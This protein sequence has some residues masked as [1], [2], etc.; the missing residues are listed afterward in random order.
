MKLCFV[1]G[2]IFAWGKYGGFGRATRWIARDLAA[3]GHEVTAVVACGPGQRPVETL[4]GI[5][6]LGYQPRRFWDALGL[7]RECDADVYHSQE[8]SLATVLAQRARP[9]RAHVVTSRDPRLAYDWCLEFARPTISRARVVANLLYEDSPLVHRAVRRADQVACTARFLEPRVRR[10]YRL[11]AAPI[12]LPSPVEL[13]DRVAKAGRPTVCFLSRWDR[14]KRPERFLELADRF[15]EVRFIA[16]GRSRDARFDRALR[17]QYGGRPN[18][19]M[20]GFVDQFAGPRLSEILSES[21]IVVNTATREG[22]PNAFLEAAAHGCAILSRVD[23]EGFASS[24]GRHVPD[25]D[26]GGGLRWL[27]EQDR[28]RAGGQAARGYVSE[29]YERRHAVDLHEALYREL[30]A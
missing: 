19:E 5:I 15:P 10:K 9:D 20:P 6:V 12:F 27:L 22:L 14:R 28:W 11:A 25:D 29:H 23:P 16:L 1:C 18:L 30:L 8:P 3:R 2:E 13:P 17:E 24:F 4:D 7:L 26:F 21:W